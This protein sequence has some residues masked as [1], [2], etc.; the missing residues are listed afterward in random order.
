MDLRQLEAFVSVATLRSFGAAASRLSLTQPAISLRVKGLESALGVRLFERVGHGVRLTARGIELLPHAERILEASHAMRASAADSAVHHQTVRVGSVS[1][2]ASAWIP[3]LIAEVLDRINHLSFDLLVEPTLRL[4]ERLLAGEIDVAIVMG[5][6]QEPGIRNV[7]LGTY[8][9]QWI[10]SHSMVIPRGRLTLQDVAR[11]PIITHGRESATYAELEEMF[12]VRGL[13]PVRLIASS[14]AEA[15][16]RLVE[17]GSA[18]GLISCACLEERP[19]ADIRVLPCEIPL[20]TH[21]FFAAFHTD[22]VGKLGM[23]V[24]EMA[25]R[26]CRDPDRSRPRLIPENDAVLPVS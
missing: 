25:Q 8:Q 18:I 7:P 12:R 19:S 5:E 9:M 6:I 13:W 14:P 22:S 1:A 21:T 16:I 3:H 23:R 4:R 20:P 15:I 24:A 11:Y 17:L 10:A 26:V 2:M